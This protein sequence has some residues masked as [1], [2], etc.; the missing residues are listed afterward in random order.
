M[1]LRYYGV[2]FQQT[3]KKYHKEEQVDNQKNSIDF[4]KIKKEE[5][6]YNRL[7]LDE[8]EGRRIDIFLESK[9]A[10]YISEF[11]VR[12][13]C[14]KIT[15]YINALIVGAIIQ[16]EQEEYPVDID[17][18]HFQYYLENLNKYDFFN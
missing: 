10:H 3:R 16:T 8:Q 4:K 13:R 2:S 18:E 5:W 1:I 7:L 17:N 14:E 15:G 12:D 6:S 9:D 11:I